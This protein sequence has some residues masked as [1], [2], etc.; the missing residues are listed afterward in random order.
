MKVFCGNYFIDNK[1]NEGRTAH[2]G[3]GLWRGG[4]ARAKFFGGIACKNEKNKVEYSIHRKNK[5][6]LSRDTAKKR[7]IQIKVDNHAYYAVQTHKREKI[8][9]AVGVFAPSVFGVPVYVFVRN[10]V[11]EN[12]FAYEGW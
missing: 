5:V 6:G 7:G 10:N 12:A 2:G 8:S 9:G 1:N 11:K 3:K 4:Q